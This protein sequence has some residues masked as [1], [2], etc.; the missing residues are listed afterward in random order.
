MGKK[1]YPE[2]TGL[3]AIMFNPVEVINGIC[4][5]QQNYGKKSLFY[6]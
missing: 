4:H 3:Q 5:K 1:L 2:K 6:F